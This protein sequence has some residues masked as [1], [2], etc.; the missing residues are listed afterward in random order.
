MN[1]DDRRKTKKNVG[2]AFVSASSGTVK[3]TDIESIELSQK[4]EAKRGRRAA[5]IE[6][7]ITLKGS[8][9]K[10][11]AESVAAKEVEFEVVVNGL[12]TKVTQTA[13]V[14][15]IVVATDD[16]DSKLLQQ[17]TETG[18]TVASK[19][20]AFKSITKIKK[21]FKAIKERYRAAKTNLRKLGREAKE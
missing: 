11:T 21:A 20:E 12:A 1:E 13:A 5:T 8:V 19:N 17:Y 2:E 18:F 4:E 6:V 9:D 7:T 3:E 16:C 14:T 15:E 10:S